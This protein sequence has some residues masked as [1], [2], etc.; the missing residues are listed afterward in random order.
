MAQE[1]RYADSDGVSI[2]WRAVGDGARDV[3]VIPGLVSHLELLWDHPPAQ[4]FLERLCSFARVIV[5]DKREQG[6]SD[7]TGRPPTLE[8]SMDDLHAVLDAAGSRRVTLVGVSEGGPMALLFAATYPQRT[9][10]LV[11][12][13]SFARIA[14]APGFA[15]GVPEDELGRFFDVIRTEWATDRVLRPFAP[16]ATPADRE[17]GRRLLRSG[18]SPA[19]AH[20][21]LQLYLAIDVRDVLPAIQAPTLV[22]HRT[23]DRIAPVAQGRYM[24]E[25]IP[26]ARYVELPGD[27]HIPFMG[28]QDDLLDEIEEHVTGTRSQRAPDRV[29]ATVLFTDICASTE[30]AAAMGDARWRDVLTEHDRLV[31]AEVERRRGRLVK[32]TGDGALATFDG[33]ARA[34]EGAA[35]IRDAVADLGLQVR[36]GLHT[37]ECELIGDDVGGIAVHI[38]ARVAATAGP[39]EIRVSRTVADLVAGSG[40][41]FEDRGEHALK[42]V[43]G[44]WRLLAVAA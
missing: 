29:L 11:V 44:A 7:R 37:G 1:I 21:L 27:A 32:S 34:I 8:E 14:A 36:A 17:W 10:R 19:G 12:V 24:A 9:A 15:P 3:V 43:P 18:S 25:Q 22:L 2:A 5:Y 26:G 4:H 6:L 16:T 20:S 33:P 31:R 38:G 39:G 40:L 28:R 42:G 23:G 13:G 30:R 41:V 35:A